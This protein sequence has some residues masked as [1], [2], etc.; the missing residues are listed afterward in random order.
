MCSCP[1]RFYQLTQWSRALL[2]SLEIAHIFNKLSEYYEPRRFITV[3]TTGSQLILILNHMNPYLLVYLRSVSILSS[4]L[5]VYLRHGLSP[6]SLP[7]TTQQ[8]FL[9]LLQHSHSS[10]FDNPN[11]NIQNS[12][13]AERCNRNC[14]FLS[15]E[16]SS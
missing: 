3:F 10:R 12:L 2:D 11:N 16:Q 5:R 8:V 14:R 6:S 1:F 15:I 7:A 4:H 9:V 13:L